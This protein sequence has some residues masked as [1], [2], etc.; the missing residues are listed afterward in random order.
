MYQVELMI[1]SE[2]PTN[3]PNGKSVVNYPD[4]IISSQTNEYTA[5]LI[6]QHKLIDFMFYSDCVNIRRQVYNPLF[7]IKLPKLM[8]I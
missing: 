4:S 5:T 1:Q 3:K 7:T 2:L 6:R 8:N